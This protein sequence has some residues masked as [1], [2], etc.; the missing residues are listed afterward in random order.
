MRRRE[1][2]IEATKTINI[3]R[4]EFVWRSQGVLSEIFTIVDILIN[5]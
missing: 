2:N 3:Y 1:E 5:Y 4:I